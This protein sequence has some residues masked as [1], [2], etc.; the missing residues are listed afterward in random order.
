MFKFK[1]I[2]FIILI[3]EPKLM[4]DEFC[5]CVT[6]SFSSNPP[7]ILALISK[8]I[9]ESANLTVKARI[10]YSIAENSLVDSSFFDKLFK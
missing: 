8:G 6:R 9:T 7:I 4:K 5:L 2:P 3:A 10:K 1:D